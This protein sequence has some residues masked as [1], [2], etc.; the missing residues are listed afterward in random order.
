MASLQTLELRIAA[1]EARLA[2]VEGGYGD[3]IY[4]TH[5]RLMKHELRWV[6]LFE[7]FNIR[8]VSEDDVDE[9]L[10]QE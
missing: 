3:A 7:H 5:R 9:A 1:L 10:D 4:K 6:K 8:D 2:E